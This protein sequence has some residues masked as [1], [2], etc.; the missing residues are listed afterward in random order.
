MEMNYESGIMR[1]VFVFVIAS[2]SGISVAPRGSSAVTHQR[3]L[4]R[5]HLQKQ[6]Y[7]ALFTGL[8]MF[9]VYMLLTVVILALF[10]SYSAT[11]TRFPTFTI[12]K[13]CA[14]LLLTNIHTAW[15]HTVISKPM[16][17]SIWERIPGWRGWLGTLPVASLDI[18][19]PSCVYYLTDLLL[20]SLRDMPVANRV[21]ELIP[22]ELAPLGS[23]Y[24]LL[25]PVVLESL[26][27]VWT[28]G[29]YVKVAASMLPNDAETVVPLDR[30]YGSRA[31]QDGTY[32]SILDAS[33]AIKLQN[34]HRYVRVLVETFLYETPGLGLFILVLAAE[35]YFWAPPCTVME[36][37]ALFTSWV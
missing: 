12:Y 34:W 23:I 8:D 24:F 21:A 2:I 35:L 19:L 27:S 11:V 16:G 36:L 31:R 4:A 22:A 5:Q 20:E 37:L 18:L 14:G 26:V 25:F 15:I 33:R 7:R 30:S 29:I 10:N 17:K 3:S 9:F 1:V 6:G 13:L 28:R 32:S